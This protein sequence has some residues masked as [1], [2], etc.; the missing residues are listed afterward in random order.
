MSQ[1]LI[2][3]YLA[4]LDRIRKVSGSTR[5]SVLREAFKDLLKS[6]GRQHDLH[7]V[8]EYELDTAT[9]D[10][11]YVDGALL[12]ELRVPFGY[13]EAKD[14]RDN[15]D[16]EIAAKFRRGYPQDNIVFEDTREAVLIQHREQVM[17]CDVTD[18]ARLQKLLRLFFDYQRP[19]IANFRRAVEQFKADLPAV[20]AALRAMIEKA[21]RD[22]ATFRAAAA[23]FLD[24]AQQAINPVLGDADVRE[25]L[26][27]HILTEEIF[28]KVF[29]EDDFHRQNNVAKEL[30]ELEGT[31]FTGDVKKR[32][33]RALD[34]YYQAI[35]SAAAQIASHR[36]KQA[37]LK[38]IYENFYKVYN[39]KAADRLGVVYTPD[40]IVRFMIDGADWLCEQHFGRSLIDRDVEILDPATGTGTFVCELLEHFRGQPKKLERKYREEL[41]A[42]EVAILP[43]YVANLNIEAT[44]AAI[45]GKYEEFANLCFV[46]TLDNVGLHTQAHGTTGHLFGSVSEENVAR[47]KRQNSRRIS[48][49]IGNPPYNANQA[50]EN[51]NNKNREYPDDD[52]RIK[53]TYIHES[54]AQKTKLYD[55]YA[56]F[57]RWASDRLDAN[58]VLAFISNRSFIDSRTFDGFRKTVAQEFAEVWVMDLGGDVRANP[59]LSGTRHNVFGI[60]TGVAISLLVRKAGHA[61]GKCRIRYARRPELETAEEKLAFLGGTRLAAVEFEEIS[62][63]KKANWLNLT[64]NDFDELM[65]LASKEAKAATTPKAERSIFKLYSLGVV[66]NRDEWVYGEGDDEVLRKVRHL[67]ASYNAD[68]VR[69]EGAPRD[70][71]FDHLLDTAIKWTRAVKNDLRVGKAYSLDPAAM[72]TSFYRPFKKLRLYF[73]RELNEMLYQ[74]PQLFGPHAGP[75]KAFCFSTDERSGFAALA[76]DAVPNKDVFMPSAA[77]V[78]AFYRYD[79]HGQRTDNIT[80]WSLKQFTA[81]Y[82]AGPGKRLPEPTK[83]GI[84]HYVY[85]VLHDPAYRETYAQNLKREFPRV[86]LLGATRADFWRWAEWGR[87]LMA[88]HIGYETVTPFSGIVRS[89]VPDLKARAAGQAPRCVLRADAEAGRIVLDSE[90][91]L[92]GIPPAGVE[93]PPRQSQRDRLGARPAQGTQA[94]GPDDPRALRHLPLRRPQGA[95]D[96]PAGARDHRQP[97]DDADRRG[98]QGDTPMT[99][100]GRPPTTAELIDALAFAA[101]KHRDQRRKDAEASPYINH[102]IALARLLSIEAGVNERV[103]L[104]AALLHDTVEDT[105]TT[106]TE[107][108]ARFGADVAE[109]VL[110]VTDDK[111]LPKARHKALQIEH[112]PHL[113]R[114]A[115]L[116]KLADKICNL[117]DMAACPPAGWPIERRRDYFDWAHGVIDGLRGVYPGLE[118]IFDAAHSRV[119]DRRHVPADATLSPAIRP[120]QQR[121]APLRKFRSSRER[122]LHRRRVAGAHV[123]VRGEWRDAEHRRDQPV[124]GRS[125]S[126]RREARHAARGVRRALRRAGRQREREHAAHAVHRLRRDLDR[127]RRVE[128]LRR[129]DLAAGVVDAVALAQRAGRRT[130]LRRRRQDRRAR[131]VRERDRGGGHRHAG[132][133]RG[134]AAVG[135]DDE[136]VAAHRYREQHEP[137]DLAGG[138]RRRRARDDAVALHADERRVA[139][140]RRIDVAD[141]ALVHAGQHGD[142]RDHRLEVVLARV[143]ALH[144]RLAGVEVEHDIGHL[145]GLDGEVD[146]HLQAGL[147]PAR[148]VERDLGAAA[149]ELDRVLERRTAVV[150]GQHE[151]QLRVLAGRQHGLPELVEDAVGQRAQV[152]AARGVEHHLRPAGVAGAGAGARMHAHLLH[153][154]VDLGEVTA[155]RRVGQREAHRARL[156]GPAAAAARGEHERR[157][158]DQLL[159]MHAGNPRDDDEPCL[160]RRFAAGVSACENGLSAPARRQHI[161]AARRVRVAATPRRRSAP[162]WRRRRRGRRSR[163]AAR[164]PPTDPRHATWRGRTGGGERGRRAR[165]SNRPTAPARC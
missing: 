60:Q 35:K 85:A 164:S 126:D 135:G 76:F 141:D 150:V 3:R 97:R 151:P 22:N 15:L 17:R 161:R 123:D 84:F 133:H 34:A 156:V 31:F 107:L 83:E 29:G 94:E 70:A 75:N 149:G 86:P 7:F 33:L 119:P 56:R 120:A 42:N 32:T 61:A 146:V 112:A 50:N 108:A 77:Q 49:I 36:E 118:A 82:K 157:Q 8:P 43:Y 113:S 41:H 67:I 74:V 37:F 9:K 6:W 117:R 98:H 39:V 2:S 114:G 162:R 100:D 139:G 131:R 89:D 91:T 102:P 62:P 158:Q 59:K 137:A 46:D 16:D 57:F 101:D 103:P 115:K 144:D 47:I 4:E 40:E 111:T 128:R 154:D 121:P 140:D 18:V 13:W 96:R 28:S 88:L 19:E 72:V 53:Q 21:Y 92:G 66:T 48:V 95:R 152:D 23:A 27:Q 99:S 129:R 10:R 155:S 14:E 106:P 55:M 165:S 38:V 12:H 148:R 116:V 69:L 125:A 26:I 25:M 160:H 65:P 132:H 5:E 142:H 24:H 51:D 54:A 145:A 136:V 1:L 63:D 163:S 64:H 122:E 130:H 159:R 87:E 127:Q 124:L 20:L 134:G 138:H 78:L 143:A 104:L 147:L 81:H 45:T 105:Q 68:V 71:R 44:Y 110:E 73:N 11:R 90:T 109:V 52:R 80:D 79:A 153:G 58:G 93:L 30:Y